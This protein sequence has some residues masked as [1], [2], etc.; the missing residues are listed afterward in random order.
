AL[1]GSLPVV[2]R[3]APTWEELFGQPEAAY[4][5]RAYNEGAP[6]GA[7]FAQLDRMVGILCFPSEGR[8]RVRVFKYL[9]I[10]VVRLDPSEMPARG[11]PRIERPLLRADEVPH[12]E[13]PQSRFVLGNNIKLPIGAEM[14]DPVHQRL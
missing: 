3:G 8:T 10:A 6:L 13:Q 7:P 1:D 11:D 9:V 2:Y 12:T 4:R 5:C 14:R